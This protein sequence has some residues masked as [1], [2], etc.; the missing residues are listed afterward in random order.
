MDTVTTSTTNAATIVT[1]SG[2]IK[3][4][5]INDVLEVLIRTGG[6]LAIYSGCHYF[7]FLSVLQ[8]QSQ[9]SVSPSGPL[10]G[11]SSHG[12]LGPECSELYE[13]IVHMAAWAQNVQSCVS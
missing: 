10:G 6:K 5:A 1:K 13:V 7:A 2:P 9:N 8:V 4:Q 3:S 11:H 12:S